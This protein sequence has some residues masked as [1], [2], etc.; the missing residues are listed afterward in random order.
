[1]N[2][3]GGYLGTSYPVPTDPS[4][5]LSQT[6]LSSLAPSAFNADTLSAMFS[7][8]GMLNTPVNAQA[9]NP[10]ESLYL[11]SSQ[12]ATRLQRKQVPGMDWGQQPQQQQMGGQ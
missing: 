6:G 8:Q 3:T 11:Q 7:P 1:M 5:Y 12:D 9:T 4:Y 2:P 10:F